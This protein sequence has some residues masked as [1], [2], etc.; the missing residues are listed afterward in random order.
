MLLWLQV[1]NSIIKPAKNLNPLFII[2]IY[3]HILPVRA[4]LFSQTGNERLRF[5]RFT[6]KIGDNEVSFSHSLESLQ[7]LAFSV[8]EEYANRAYD[9]L[10]DFLENTKEWI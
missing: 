9:E 8:N 4:R 1:P 7:A 10:T 5:I 2:L 3:Y 6:G